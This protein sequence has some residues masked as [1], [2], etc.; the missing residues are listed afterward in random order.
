MP[1]KPQLLTVKEAAAY[2]RVSR[3]T[4]YRLLKRKKLP[5]AFRIGTDWRIDMITLT[6]GLASE[7]ERERS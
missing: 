4:I 2:L 7:R 1:I 3:S 5:G 6:S